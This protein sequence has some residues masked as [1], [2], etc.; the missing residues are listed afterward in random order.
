MRKKSLGLDTEL[1]TSERKSLV[2]GFGESSPGAT[3]H[4]NTR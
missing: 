1:F 2:L 4:H 3:G